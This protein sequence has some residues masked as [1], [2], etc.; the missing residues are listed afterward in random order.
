MIKRHRSSGRKCCHILP[1]ECR[2]ARLSDIDNTDAS[3]TFDQ[4]ESLRETLKDLSIAFFCAT[5][6]VSIR[7]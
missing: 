3:G 2:L 5:W 7:R 4:E 6:S 1:E